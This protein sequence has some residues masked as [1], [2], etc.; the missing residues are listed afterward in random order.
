MLFFFFPLQGVP[1]CILFRSIQL[2]TSAYLSRIIGNF[3]LFQRYSL[4]L[5]SSPSTG[6]LIFHSF[7]LQK[8][9]MKFSSGVYCIIN[10]GITPDAGCYVI[11]AFCCDYFLLPL[12]LSAIVEKVR[13]RVDQL[14]ISPM[15]GPR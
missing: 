9:E 2:T 10:N 15:W 5:V 12:M 7:I 1:R 8:N 14:Q 13:T 11:M 3:S 4:Q 6:V